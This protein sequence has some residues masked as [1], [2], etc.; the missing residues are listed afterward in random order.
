[1]SARDS[2]RRP[3]NDRAAVDKAAIYRTSISHV[4]RTPLRN[5]FTYRSYCWYVDVD[6]LPQFPRLLRP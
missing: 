3:A 6:H 1:M 4:R 2:I 5:A